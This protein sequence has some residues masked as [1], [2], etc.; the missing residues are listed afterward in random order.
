MLPYRH[1][2]RFEGQFEGRFRGGRRPAFASNSGCRSVGRAAQE[3]GGLGWHWQLHTRREVYCNSER[4]SQFRA[5]YGA[6][7][8]QSDLRYVVVCMR[9]YDE[10]VEGNCLQDLVWLDPS[11][12]F[13]IR[14]DTR[15][16][17]R[18]PRENTRFVT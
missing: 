14:L 1:R 2:R 12:P 9:G 17:T 11:I 18:R 15:D 3:V 13:R 7:E 8:I 10:K 6:P 5:L 16:S 4:F